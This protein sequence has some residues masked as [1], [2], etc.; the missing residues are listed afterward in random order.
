MDCAFV[1]AGMSLGASECNSTRAQEPIG[2]YGS[3][4]VSESKRTGVWKYKCRVALC[5]RH[6]A[7]L[8]RPPLSPVMAAAWPVMRPVDMYKVQFLFRCPLCSSERAVEKTSNQSLTV[9]HEPI[10]GGGRCYYTQSHGRESNKK[11]KMRKC[12][13]KTFFRD[14]ER[15]GYISVDKQ[16]LEEVAYE[17][18]YSSSWAAPGAARR[19]SV[20][21]LTNGACQHSVNMLTNGARRHSVKILINGAYPVL[22]VLYY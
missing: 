20:N 7:R 13:R 12:I 9:L 15:T 11:F 2:T 4:W 21:L 16:Y 10:P 18:D 8:S 5:S 6:A 14:H 17:S 22:L 19:H 3:I 1:C